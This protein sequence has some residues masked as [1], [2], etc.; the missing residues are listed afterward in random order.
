[1]SGTCY[2]EYYY[3][4]NYFKEQDVLPCY[5]CPIVWGGQLCFLPIPSKFTKMYKHENMCHV[6]FH[7]LLAT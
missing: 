4:I 7:G 1:M 3:A 6:P 2:G 5:C